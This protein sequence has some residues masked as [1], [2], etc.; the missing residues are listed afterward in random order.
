VFENASNLTPKLFKILRRAGKGSSKPGR[1]GRRPVLER[2][3]SRALLSTIVVNST[4]DTDP[5]VRSAVGKLT[6]R[7]AILLADLSP[8]LPYASLTPA[9]Q[10]QLDAPPSATAPNTIIFEIGNGDQF[11]YVGASGQGALPPITRPTIL[12]ATAFGG[13]LNPKFPTQVINLRGSPAVQK[14]ADGLTVIGGSRVAGGGSVIRGFD[15][16]FFRNG[17]ALLGNPNDFKQGNNTVEGN[18]I[19]VTSSGQ[20]GPRPFR[21]TGVGI[22]VED[23]PKDTIGSM[24]D[25]PPDLAFGR[26]NVLSNNARYG[27]EVMQSQSTEASECTIIGNF[28]GTTGSGTGAAGNGIGGVSIISANGVL[29]TNNTISANNGGSGVGISNAD[30]MVV[31]NFIGTDRFGKRALPNKFDGIDVTNGGATIKNNLISGNDR[32]GLT[33]SGT[34]QNIVTGN[35]IG[36]DP[37]GSFAIGNKMD[38]VLIEVQS[39]QNMLMGNLISGN[40]DNGVHIKDESTTNTVQSNFIGTDRTGTTTIG[41]DKKTL[42]NTGSGIL[43]DNTPD[44]TI[45]GNLISGNAQNGITLTGSMA[46]RNQVQ[47]NRVGTDRSGMV[48]LGNTRA[49][50]LINTGAHD[51][52]IGGIGDLGGGLPQFTGNANLISGNGLSG[53]EIEGSKTSDNLVGANLIGTTADGLKLLGNG[54]GNRPGT[55]GVLIDN[56]PSNSLFRN[57]ISG[58]K[59]SGV[60]ITGSNATGNKLF[61]NLIGTDNTGL[62]DLANGASGVLIENAPGNFVGL[63]TA[64]LP[65]VISGNKGD[66]VRIQGTGASGNMVKFNY[67]GTDVNG[68]IA[69]GNGGNG[70]SIVNASGTLIGGTDPANSARNVISG[71]VGAGIS[72]SGASSKTNRVINNHI[73]TGTDSSNVLP[74]EGAGVLF[75]SGTTGNAILL[76]LIAN[77]GGAGVRDL[78]PAPSNTISRNSIYLNAMMGIDIADPGPTLAG[79]P[80]FTSATVAANSTTVTGTV[81]NRPNTIYTLEFFANTERDPSGHGQGRTFL[82][83]MAVTTNG[84]GV[85]PFMAAFPTAVPAG[86]F[87]SATATDPN[88][89]TTEFSADATVVL[90]VGLLPHAGDDLYTTAENTPLT[91]AAGVGVQANDTD[92]YGFPLTSVLVS[93]PANGQ[94]TLNPNGSFTYTPNADFFGIDTFTYYD[95]DGLA[96]SN[97]ATVTIGVTPV[98][99][100]PVANPV[101]ISATEDT[102]LS[103]P[104]TNLL[105]NDT[106]GPPNE[107]GQTLTVIAVGNAVNGTVTLSGGTIT[108]TPA[109]QFTGTASF[110][111]TI[112]DNGT[113]N[114]QPDPKTATSTVTV[115]VAPPVN[116][117]TTTSVVGTPSASVYGQA[118]TFTATVTPANS[119]LGPPTG[120]VQFQVDGVNFGAPVPLISGVATSA[121]LD[122][123]AAGGHTITALY[124]GD[125]QHTASMGTVTQTVNQAETATTVVSDTPTS[126]FGQPV[127]FTATVTAQSPGGGVPTGMVAFKSLSPDG[128]IM[129]TLGTVA[130]DSTGTAVFS[131]DQLVPASHTIFAE[132]LGDGNN[133]GSTST[134]ITQVVQK[135]DTTITLTVANS[136][137]VSGQ[138]DSFN[139]SPPEVVS[140]G[141]PIVPPTGTITFYDYNPSDGTTTTLITIDL[142]QSEMGPSLTRIGTHVITAVYSGDDYFNGSTSA[143][144]TVTVIAPLT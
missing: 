143:P 129:V 133:A 10:A 43:I 54:Q 78:N 100:P 9:E 92:P 84:Q 2:L 37:T 75:A 63:N 127:T 116:V 56:A 141:A 119:D 73:G 28:I 99:Q 131:M 90:R 89:N 66:G 144:V 83:S 105:A 19:G 15:I 96:N 88:G 44:N 95:N 65:N 113:T 126:V 6:L 134:Q 53:V 104:A 48:A 34:S 67:I 8:A 47:G 123:L 23:S 39:V 81:T 137:V 76:N 87:V 121:S 60:R 36:T 74:N 62:E 85:A 93:G 68:A 35:S 139:V 115:N 82:G 101:D 140:P 24:T 77:N 16:N 45:G 70:I 106:P 108:F 59:Q 40:G 107:S 125:P 142:G 120:T 98:N 11:I 38:G 128:T 52:F 29:I 124:S 86:Q 58:N 50:I 118:V 111:Y 46:T 27:V 69:L 51:N 33:L 5:A 32:N 3:E 20:I 55:A 64:A 112:Q 80:V 61:G 102:P 97:L 72:I 7:E 114:G 1:R 71:N 110:S 57:L 103:F 94:V 117:A 25:L 30:T 17:I 31:A 122:T 26:G 4:A 41:T 138:P 130:L 79:V 13:G 91:V 18:F 109:A 42:G 21:N 136:V 49:G 14:D 135:A 132:Y 22:L 12:D